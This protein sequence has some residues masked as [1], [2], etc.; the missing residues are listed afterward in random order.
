MS[1]VDA[2]CWWRVVPD[3]SEARGRP[4][5]FL[6]RDGVVVED[7]GYLRD[8][9]KVA[10]IPG[11]ADA[12]A[13]ARTAGMAIVLVTN[14]S[15]VG[16]GYYDWAAFEAVQAEIGRRLDAEAPGARLDAE[17][18]CGFDP[19][20][21][22]GADHPWRKPAPGMLLAARDELGV[23][24][25]ASWIVGDRGGRP[26]RRRRGRAG[27]RRA[28]RDEQRGLTNEGLRRRCATRTSPLCSPPAWAPRS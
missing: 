15:G 27:R 20:G 18:A 24:L 23:E 11:A 6:D 13:R 7:V 5:L 1:G 26:R 4:A 28:C 16:R 22:A 14:Q 19:S 10:L 2:H 12:V 9:T 17:F 3:P 25:T 8:P 21:P